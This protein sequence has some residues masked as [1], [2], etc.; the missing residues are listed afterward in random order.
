MTRIV[1]IGE[2]WGKDEA[3]ARRPF[4]GA[5]G[6]ELN[7][8]LEEAGLLPPGSARDIS[9]NYSNFLWHKRDRIYAEAG[10][11]PTNV[12]NL[13][14]PGN[15]IEDLC[16]PKWGSLPPIRPGKYLREEFV[17]ELERLRKELTAE[18]PNL[19]IGMG[20]TALWFCLGRGSITKVRGA[21][22]ESPYGKFLPTFHPAFLFRGAMHLRPVV[23]FDL[24]KAGREARYPE[25]RRP[26]RRIFIPESME[27]ILFCLREII[28]APRI[29]IDIET[30]GDQI[31]CIGFAWAHNAALVIPIF[32]SRKTSKSYWPLETEQEVWRLIRHICTLPIPKVFQNGIFDMRFLWQQ[33]GITVKNAEHDTMLL[34]H[35]LHPEV[36]K[37]LGFLGSIYT[38]EVSWKI[39]RP[40]GKET[41]IKDLKEE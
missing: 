34:H 12:L 19:I 15:R 11:Y 10:I 32:D 38:D 27:D 1:L 23:L 4:V 25:V 37:G 29:S 3:A 41:T 22:A 16:G 39:M 17:P 2:A 26:P 21:I 31:T 9:P 24:I 36:Q 35:A 40:R 18:R 7:R 8:L 30:A 6:R 33:Y 20:A 13:E 14:P 28:S 5:T